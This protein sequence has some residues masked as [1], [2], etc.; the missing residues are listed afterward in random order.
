MKPNTEEILALANWPKF[1]PN[2]ANEASAEARMDRAVSAL[3][4]PGS[5]FKLITLAAAFDQD[6]IRPEE[7]FDC[8]NGA[9]Y[10]AGHRI[11]DHEPFGLLTVSDILARS[12]DVGAIKIALKLG[13]PKFYDYF[14]A[15]GSV[16]SLV[17]SFSMETRGWLMR[18]SL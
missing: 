18:G 11:R 9:V 13:A 12:S 8:E 2:A 4:E 16:Q 6:I 7:V 10:L 5:T 14:R 15:F 3:Y 17:F 1:N